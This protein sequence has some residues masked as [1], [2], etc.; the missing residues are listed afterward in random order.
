MIIEFLQ[1]ILITF[2]L[3]PV[4]AGQPGVGEERTKLEKIKTRIR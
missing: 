1:L 4:F 2:A 3:K